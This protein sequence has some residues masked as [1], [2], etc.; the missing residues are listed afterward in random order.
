MNTAIII[1]IGVMTV[2][3]PGF[4][5][6][7]LYCSTPENV[8]TYDIKTVPWV[9]IDVKLFREEWV[10]CGDEILI[11]FENGETLKALA[12]DAGPLYKY[13][14]DGVPIVADIPVH[15]APF[16]GLSARGQMVNVT[17]LK[18]ELEKRAG[19]GDCLGIDNVG[20]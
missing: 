19:N 8:L 14:I 4:W 17:T 9:A 13:K 15:L 1:V 6:N 5:G 18:R 7:H 20:F 2:Y 16:W 11:W 10:Q 12:L 3:G